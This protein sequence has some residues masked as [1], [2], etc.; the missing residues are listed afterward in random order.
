MQ[1]V[2]DSVAGDTIKGDDDLVLRGQQVEILADED[3][4]VLHDEGVGVHLGLVLAA[5][6][7]E[8]TLPLRE[9]SLIDIPQNRHAVVL[10]RAQ[11]QVGHLHLKHDKQ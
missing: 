1:K 7:G 9:T 3:R 8:V 4:D 11:L 5:Q 2:D 10:S 6:E